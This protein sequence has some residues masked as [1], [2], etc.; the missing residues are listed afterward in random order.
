MKKA[1]E[2]EQ[3]K[4]ATIYVGEYHASKRPT[5]IETL[6]GSCVAVCLIDPAQ[7][8]GGMNHILLPGEARIGDC[9]PASRYAVNAMEL[10]I[11]E[12]MALGGNRNLLVA[13]VFGGANVMSCISRANCMGMKNADFV[14]QFLELEGFP[15]S[16]RDLGGQDARRIYFRTD[17][18]EVFLK[19][20]PFSERLSLGARE[21][22][23]RERLRKEI[24]K[25]GNITLFT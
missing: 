21:Q 13:K 9:N 20:I 10:L 1:G 24:D 22:K 2:A 15:V 5:I 25:A 16:S 12:I 18:G 6:L 7:K 19:R 8:I 4:S 11:N 23:A 14:L 3:V 17:T